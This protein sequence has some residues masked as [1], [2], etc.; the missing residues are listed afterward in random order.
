[1]GFDLEAAMQGFSLEDLVGKTI[2]KA[3]TIQN[4]LPYNR[5]V[6]SPNPAAFN[7]LLF[8]DGSYLLHMN[9]GWQDGSTLHTFLVN[10]NTVR[11]AKRLYSEH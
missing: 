10:N 6:A 2:S 5:K 1:M 3:V 8:S 11:Y 9:V 4:P 7:V